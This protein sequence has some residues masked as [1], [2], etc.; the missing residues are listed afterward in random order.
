MTKKMDNDDFGF[1]PIAILK[2]FSSI[3]HFDDKNIKKI[4][5][6]LSLHH[7]KIETRKSGLEVGNILNLIKKTQN[8]PGD[9]IETGTYFGGLTILMA[10]YLDLLNN[11][12]KIFTFDSFEGMPKPKS[13]KFLDTQGFLKV[14][15]EYVKNKFKRFS[16]DNR[17]VIVKGFIEETLGTLSEKTFS[18]ALIDTNAYD[19]LKFALEFIYPRLSKHGIVAIDDYHKPKSSTESLGTQQ[20]VDEFCN[21]HNLTLISEPFAYI[22]KN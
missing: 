9:I 11:D 16:L 1:H 13:E 6:E 7:K 15:Y 17:I 21:A 5:R 3:N 10:K 14:D 22:V 19:S 4:I 18:F 2:A 8:I 12:K 20:A